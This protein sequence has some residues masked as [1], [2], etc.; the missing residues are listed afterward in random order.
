MKT[1]IDWIKKWEQG[2]VSDLIWT[3]WGKGF[4]IYPWV[5][6]RLLHKWT[7]GKETH[8]EKSRALFWG[9]VRSLF[10]GWKSFSKGSDYWMISNHLER[11]KINGKW[12]DKL[13]DPI[14]DYLGQDKC[15]FI[16]LQLFPPYQSDEVY[17]KRIISKA[18]WMLPEELIAR[19]SILFFGR[20]EFPKEFKDMMKDLDVDVDLPSIVAKNWSQYIWMTWLLK[21]IKHPKAVFLTVSYSN[22]GYIRAFKEKG[23]KVIECQHGWIGG[24]HFSYRYDAQ[25]DPI[26]FPDEM[27]VF[28]ESDVIN[29]KMA[30]FPVREIIP[31]GK[32]I[33]Q[34]Y[35]DKVPS[36]FVGVKK[37][38]VA[39]QDGIFSFELLKF[40]LECANSWG[41]DILWVIQNRRMPQEELE[42]AFTFPKNVVWSNVG[43]YDCI[44]QCDVHVT[45]YSTTAIEAL[46][47]GR[48]VCLYNWN[49]ISMHHLG[50]YMPPSSYLHYVQ[51]S[52]QMEAVMGGVSNVE[53]S[54]VVASNR[55]NIADD[56]DRR[57]KQYLDERIK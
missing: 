45:M 55:S 34:Y 48:V 56:Y 32:S 38:S 16:E 14:A 40:V 30:N 10:F 17:S 2:P 50:R 54:S 41:K 19:L 5:K 37:I 49:D 28:G 27:L 53:K 24:G 29:L 23:I 22:F 7:M 51:S 20:F 43:I 1:A 52:E 6:V 36:S 21:W 4:Q 25:M 13:F 57:L 12:K 31:I 8:V 15:R 47:I 9:Q 18:W 33:I 46:S 26:Q 39:L 3:R 35:Q 44:V 11:T 42:S